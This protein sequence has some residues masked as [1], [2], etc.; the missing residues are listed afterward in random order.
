MKAI[1]ARQSLYDN[2][3]LEETE[4]ALA[5]SPCPQIEDSRGTGE[6]AEISRAYSE[7]SR[8]VRSLRETAF[9]ENDLTETLTVGWA[10]ALAIA[11]ALTV[12]VSG[13]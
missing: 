8:R 1:H 10:M 9:D 12:Y 5:I 2:S 11:V 3:A 6:G 7:H 4:F 13:G